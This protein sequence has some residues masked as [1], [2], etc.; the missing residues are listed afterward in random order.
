MLLDLPSM[1]QALLE[2]DNLCLG[3]DML[4]YLRKYSSFIMMLIIYCLCLC[5]MFINAYGYVVILAIIFS[6]LLY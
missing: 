5:L 4:D 6:I 3:K 1:M 2:A